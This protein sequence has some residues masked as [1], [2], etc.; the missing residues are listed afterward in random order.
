VLTIVSG[1][2]D[3]PVASARV[4]VAG[5]SHTTDARGELVLQ[6]AVAPL[7]PV[8]VE[9]AGY[10]PRQTTLRSST[11][12]SLWPSASATGL[13]ADY[14]GW[15]V[16]TSAFS[17]DAAHGSSALQRPPLGT[18]QASV[19]P[20]AELLRDPQAR[21]AHENAVRVLNDALA[22]RFRYEL[23]EQRPGGLVF[24]TKLDPKSPH[25]KER[26]RAATV[27]NLAGSEVQGGTVTFCTLEAARSFTVAHELGHTFGLQHSQLAAEIMHGW[28]LPHSPTAFSPRE[29]LAMT[30]MLQR[31]AG[32]RFPDTDRLGAS[33]S[34][35]RRTAVAICR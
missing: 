32:N 11:R 8:D 23:V 30:L 1:E 22:G 10:L 33:A 31:G 7:A 27:T 16:Y 20:S 5:Q 4:T 25:C 29:A 2:T 24:E 13:D 14:S 3:A 35:A 6:S 34:Q 19:V 21:E 18:T 9:A 26:V 17:P 12:F 15:L 28:Y